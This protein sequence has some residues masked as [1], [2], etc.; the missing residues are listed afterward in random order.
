M[1]KE[2]RKGASRLEEFGLLATGVVSKVRVATSGY[3]A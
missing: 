1:R 2:T 3:K